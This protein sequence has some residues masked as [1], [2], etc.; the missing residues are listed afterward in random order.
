MRFNKQLL[1]G[2]I[3]LLSLVAIAIAYFVVQEFVALIT[4]MFTLVAGGI[5]GTA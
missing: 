2:L 3:V 1:T 4:N 5:A